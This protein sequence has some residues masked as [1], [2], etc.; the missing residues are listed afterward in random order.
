MADIE[1]RFIRWQG[2]TLSQLSITLSLLSGLSVAGLG[3]SLC[4]RRNSMRPNSSAISH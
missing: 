1:E 2:H 4:R 3:L